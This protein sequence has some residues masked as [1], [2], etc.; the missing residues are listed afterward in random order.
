M[1]EAVVVACTK[2]QTDNVAVQALAAL[3][4]GLLIGRT[5]R[6]QVT[7]VLELGE[8]KILSRVP[9]DD[10]SPPKDTDVLRELEWQRVW[11]W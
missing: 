5:Q 4:K 8:T 2:V 7:L 3:R 11:N 10:S 6:K 9:N 1:F